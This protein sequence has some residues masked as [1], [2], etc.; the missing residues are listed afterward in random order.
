MASRAKFELAT[1]RLT[2]IILARQELDS[3]IVK[4]NEEAAFHEHLLP[5]HLVLFYPLPKPAVRLNIDGP[6][7]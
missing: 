4:I 7:N 6:S 5:I 2:V 3:S 1:L